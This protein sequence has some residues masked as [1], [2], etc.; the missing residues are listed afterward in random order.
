MKRLLTLL[1]VAI[2]ALGA[3]SC[4]FAEE[5]PLDVVF[6]CIDMQGAFW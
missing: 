3:C 5:D 1:L 4:A 2:V 6:V